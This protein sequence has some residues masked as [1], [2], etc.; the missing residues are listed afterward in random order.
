M[1]AAINCP[2]KYSL[3]FN[4]LSSSCFNSLSIRFNIDICLSDCNWTRTH[5]QLVHKRTLNHLAKPFNKAFLA[6]VLGFQF[7]LFIWSTGSTSWNSCRATSSFWTFSSQ[8]SSSLHPA[9]ISEI[10]SGMLHLVLLGFRYA[11]TRKSMC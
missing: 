3:S 4:L 9:E 11:K 10:L 8:L 2:Y 5:N 6:F 1:A 7:L